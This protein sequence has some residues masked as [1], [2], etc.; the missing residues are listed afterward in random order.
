M[1]AILKP[2]YHRLSPDFTFH[3][4]DSTITNQYGQRAYTDILNRKDG[5]ELLTMCRSCMSQYRFRDYWNMN[6][7]VKHKVEIWPGRC[8]A[9]FKCCLEWLYLQAFGVVKP[10]PAYEDYCWKALQ[11]WDQGTKEWCREREKV[12][13][14]CRKDGC[15]CTRK[16][17]ASIG[18]GK[19]LR[20]F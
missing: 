16:R 2:L 14:Q 8:G 12:F 13:A 9:C 15:T 4:F 7:S 10:N 3:A 6:L 5:V 17:F 20:K 19:G 11:K 18:M 1:N